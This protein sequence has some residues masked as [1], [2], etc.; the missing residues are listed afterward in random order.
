M[1]KKFKGILVCLMVTTL[2]LS[3]IM[4]TQV[5]AS[6]KVD[7]S[8]VFNADYY[9]NAYADLRSAI[10]YDREKLLQHFITFGMQEGRRGN[11]EF[12]VKAYMGN[13]PDLMQAFGPNDLKSYYFHYISYGKKEGRNAA[14]TNTNISI[15]APAQSLISSYTTAFDASQSRAV[16]IALAASKIN[17]TLIKPGQQFSFSDTVGPRTAENGFVLAT[18]FVNGQEVP[19]IGGG[20]CQV[21]STMYAA[22]LQG[23]I[24]AT[25]RYPHSKPVSY[26]PEGMDATIVAGQKDLTFTNNFAF[27]IVINAVVKDGTIT[28]SFSK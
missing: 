22:M 19:G 20:I 16:N 21:S 17:G 6:D 15:A 12:D 14:S 9:F 24:Q 26:I 3:G 7:Y 8:A 5:Q 13:Y 11:A 25:Q 10:G 2:V 27:A 23:G 1:K 18:T 28:V 4:P